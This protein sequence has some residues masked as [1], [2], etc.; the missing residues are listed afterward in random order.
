MDIEKMESALAKFIDLMNIND[1]TELEV[2]EGESSIRLKKGSDIVASPP[3]TIVNT[4]SDAVA[5]DTQAIQALDLTSESATE[6]SLIE[7][8]SP[9]V[10][11]FYRA[12]S[13]DSDP[14]VEAGDDVDNDTVLCIVEAMKVMNEIKSEVEGRIV[15]ILVE[16]GQSV[17]FGQGLFIIN[18][19]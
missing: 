13:P 9:L 12:P 4:A 3:T 6:S 19:S 1:L 17:E 15:E 11:T 8:P 18:P 2:T 5:S 14:F 10:G 16:N 7:I